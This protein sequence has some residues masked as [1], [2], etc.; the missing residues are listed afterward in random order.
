MFVSR[1]PKLIK[2]VA[3]LALASV[4]A[5]PA[6]AAELLTNGNFESGSYA[7]WSANVRAGSSGSLFIDTPG[8]TTPR[9]GFTSAANLLGGNFYSTTDQNGPGSYSLVQNFLVP[10]SLSSLTLAFQLFANNRAGAVTVNPNG[11][12]HNFNPNQHARVDILRAGADPFTNV[13]SDIVANLFL[14][15]DGNATN[16]YRSFSFDLK[17]LGL[18]G[19]TGYQIRFGQVDNQGF[20]QLGVDNVS[21]DALAGVPEPASWAMMLVG[22]GLVGSAVRRRPKLRVTLA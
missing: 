5:T 20:F 16:P 10:T 13:A 22:F 12:N 7:G 9:S 3:T 21:I 1:R 14:G 8:T 4:I 17:A 19:G 6:F 18:T 15:A 2:F 11:L